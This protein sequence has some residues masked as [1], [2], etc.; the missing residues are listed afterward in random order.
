MV[1]LDTNALVRYFTKDDLIKAERVKKLLEDEKQIRIPEAV[2]PEIEY[3][4]LNVYAATRNNI[5]EAFQFLASC[6]NIQLPRHILAAIVLYAQT[7]FDMADCLVVVQSFKGK[8]A[9]FDKRLTAVSGVRVYW[10]EN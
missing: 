1:Y 6:A 2:F 9:S 4:L 10:Q 7:T 5:A 3:V 8:L